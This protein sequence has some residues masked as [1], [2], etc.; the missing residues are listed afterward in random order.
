[1]TGPL[2][3]PPGPRAYPLVGTLPDLGRRS[4]HVALLDNWRR[5]GDVIRFVF[6]RH[7]IVMLVHPEHARHVLV[8]HRANYIKGAGVDQLRHF[9]GDGLFTADGELWQ[10]QRRMMQPHFTV[11]AVR[12]YGQ[13]ME[14]S[15]AEA[16]GRLAERAAGGA[17]DLSFELMRFTMDVICRTMFSVGAGGE[18]AGLSEAITEAMHWT[19]SRGTK[20][21]QVPPRVP[22]PANLRFSRAVVEIDRFLLGM[23]ER[24]RKAGEVGAR[25]DLLDVL[26]QASDE[27]TG[28]G[29]SVQQLRD[30]MVT[31]F[32]AGHE[33]T[34][35]SLGWALYLLTQ[36]REAQEMLHAEATAALGG[37]APTAQ[38]LP[39]LPATR[40]VIEEAL[41][42]F[43]PVWVNPRQAVA[44]D[45]VDGYRIPA[46]A[47]VLMFAYATHRH[48]EFWSDPERFDPD[49]FLPEQVQ[50]RHP[51]AYM[52]FGGGNRVC[53]GMNFALQEMIMALAAFVQRFAVEL[54]PGWLLG[55]DPSSGTLRPSEPLRVRLRPRG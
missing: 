24:R 53:I 30:E 45:E 42:M 9:T 28:R 43:P 55:F 5:H 51:I 26:L 4:L 39:A 41:R 2:K 3:T 33:T 11:A 31:V 54:A 32:V 40:R 38:D 23:I 12:A 47:T 6:G 18:A 19:G 52:P 35:I 46:G 50:A 48:P 27:E 21:V 16:L 29:M 36:H 22:T 8:K 15:I 13:A 10:T 49:R 20:M 44:E 1:M 14:A 34:A 37:R 17:I 7:E 25:G